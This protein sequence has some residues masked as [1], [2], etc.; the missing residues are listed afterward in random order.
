VTIPRVVPFTKTLAP[1]IPSPVPASVTLPVILACC[2]LAEK[3]MLKA[4]REKKT[5]N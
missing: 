5:Q 2:A 4:K 1:G 3:P